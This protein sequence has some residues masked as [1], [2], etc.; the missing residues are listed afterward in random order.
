MTVLTRQD[1]GGQCSIY[2]SHYQ[3]C[4]SVDVAFFCTN[5]S[6]KNYQN[7]FMYEEVIRRKG[8]MFFERVC[9]YSAESFMT[10]II[11]STA[12]VCCLQN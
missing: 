5:I 10:S 12:C 6:A 3:V 7:W 1:V 11:I 4:H 8:E 9:M 2:Y